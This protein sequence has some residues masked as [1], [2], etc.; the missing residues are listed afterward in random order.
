[1]SPAY[2][3][4]A[5]IASSDTWGDINPLQ[6]F[7]AKSPLSTRGTLKQGGGI[8]IHKDGRL[9]FIIFTDL[10]P[11]TRAEDGRENIL[12]RERIVG[13][14]ISSAREYEMVDI[15]LQRQAI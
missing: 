4:F 8:E 14:Y 10:H 5:S 3:G 11:P 12:D 13:N 1:M 6:R 2:G 9:D 7:H 15:K